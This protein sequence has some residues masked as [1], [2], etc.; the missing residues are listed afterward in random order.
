MLETLVIKI[1]GGVVGGEVRALQAGGRGFES[2][3]VHQPFSFQQNSAGVCAEYHLL[4]KQEVA[5]NNTTMPAGPA[6]DKAST[7]ASVKAGTKLLLYDSSTKQAYE[8]GDQ[9]K[10]EH[11]EKVTHAMPVNF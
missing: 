2:R 7:L 4:L 11:G 8:L 6:S 1:P 3:H 10:A 5:R 9:K